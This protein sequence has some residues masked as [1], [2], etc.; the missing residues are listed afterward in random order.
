MK[1]RDE[2]KDEL[3]GLSP[4]LWK[5]KEKPD[6]FEVPKDYFKSLPDE[7]LKKMNV[8]Q[9]V[10]HTPKINWWE[11]LMEYF[12]PLF[13]PKYTLAIAS[14]TL[15]MVAGIFY[16]KNDST[17]P[18]TQQLLAEAILDQVPDDILQDYISNNIDDFD[19]SI[20]KEELTENSEDPLPEFE[21]NDP[22]ELMDELI[23]ELDIS[24]LEELL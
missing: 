10:E 2:I 16:M 3:E 8:G 19:E 22:D 9:K 5:Q 12:Q 6:G 17:E 15:L 24:E 13:Q 23:D 7:V 11:N 4:F 18:H 1:N 21:I 20:L 14:F